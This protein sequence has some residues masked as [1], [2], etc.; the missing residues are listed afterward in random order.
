MTVRAAPPRGVRDRPASLIP[1]MSAPHVVRALGRLALAAVPLWLIGSFATSSTI[2]PSIRAVIVAVSVLALIAPAEGLLI[3]ALLTPFGDLVAIGMMAP[4]RFAE[5][6]VV[7][8]L[9]GW[10]LRPAFRRTIGPS[11]P[12]TITYSAWGVAAIVL[13]SSAV[14]ALQLRATAPGIWSTGVWML[15]HTYF[16]IIGDPFGV[17]TGARV[18]EGIGLSAAA[19]ALLRTKPML[20][21]WIPEALGIGCVLAT[22]SSLLLWQGIAFPA[23]LARHAL[24]GSRFSALV[25]DVNAAGSYFALLL[26]LA[27]G[28]SARERGS[29]RMAWAA[30]GVSALIGLWLSA[31]RSATA[32]AV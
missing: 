7:A 32:A 21:N 5:A 30:V 31:S 12:A 3:V 16:E 25:G 9:A 6:L 1:H 26:C 24:I 11:P 28:M 27:A 4:L 13:A 2:D 29:K 22:I 15:S 17:V 23:I 19:I 8:F 14:Q 10:L 20:A 18:L